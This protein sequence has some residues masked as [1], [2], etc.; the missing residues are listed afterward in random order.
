VDGLCGNIHGRKI[1]FHRRS[2]GAVARAALCSLFRTAWLHSVYLLGRT[3][4]IWGPR[5]PCI[6][7]H[8]PLHQGKPSG[9][10]ALRAPSILARFVFG[11][12]LERELPRKLTFTT[13][14]KIL[15]LARKGEAWGTL[16]N[17]QA[18]ERAIATGQ[19]GCYWRLTPSQ[20]ARLRRP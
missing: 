11:G 13:S 14:G 12:G 19:G 17:R 8:E 18:L 4:K 16:E 2:Q 1:R 10:H 15:E 3:M 20:N 7:Q 9:L 6:D 5:R